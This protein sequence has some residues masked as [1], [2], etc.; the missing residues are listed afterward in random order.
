MAD[1]NQGLLNFFPMNIGKKVWVVK[2]GVKFEPKNLKVE[3]DPR[4]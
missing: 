1:L 3:F 4:Q 2:G